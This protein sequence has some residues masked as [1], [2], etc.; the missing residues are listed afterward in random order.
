MGH[1]RHRRLSLFPD[2]PQLFAGDNRASSLRG[3]ELVGASL[4]EYLDGAPDV[5]PVVIRTYGCLAYHQAIDGQFVMP[6][7]AA[8]SGFPSELRPYFDVLQRDPGPAQATEEYIQISQPFRMAMDTLL[9]AEPL[10]LAQ[11]EASLAPP[12]L[13]I[14]HARA[15]MRLLACELL[16]EWLG[17]LRGSRQDV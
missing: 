9:E 7:P 6:L 14:Y 8:D 12:Y 10:L 3:R 5:S 15:K 16:N 17:A 11:W 2:Q 4:E 13:Q 1:G